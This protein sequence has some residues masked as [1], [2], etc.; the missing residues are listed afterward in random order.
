VL[1]H[2]VLWGDWAM[3]MLRTFHEHWPSFNLALRQLR[4]RNVSSWRRWTFALKLAHRALCSSRLSEHDE[5][6]ACSTLHSFEKFSLFLVD[7]IVGVPDFQNAV[8]TEDEL[9]ME[10]QVDPTLLRDLPFLELQFATHAVRVFS[11]WDIRDNCQT[12]HFPQ[13]LLR[14]A[15]QSDSFER[16]R[17]APRLHRKRYAAE[18]PQT[19]SHKR[20]RQQ[21]ETI[22]NRSV[23]TTRIA[24]ISC[25]V[26]DNASPSILL[27]SQIWTSAEQVWKQKAK[28]QRLISNEN[29]AW[30]QTESRFEG[31]TTSPSYSTLQRKGKRGCSV[32]SEVDSMP[33]R[34]HHLSI[35]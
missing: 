19:N 25:E 4:L 22:S 30:I 27:N 10:W 2:H 5:N 14:H 12:R 15:A 11:A 34:V 9:L 26:K 1:T 29:D 23:W 6:A 13:F 18:H 31:E 3:R 24:A 32:L 16:K 7:S 20:Q 21:T 8:W 35:E 28:R 17:D 33:A